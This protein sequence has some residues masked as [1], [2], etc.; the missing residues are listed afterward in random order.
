VRFAF[1]LLA[2][3]TIPDPRMIRAHGADKSAIEK[4]LPAETASHLR[5]DPDSK[6]GF[7]GFQQ[8][9][10]VWSDI[11]HINADVGRD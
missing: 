7:A 1:E 9:R 3:E 2:S 4:F 5:N 10:Q 8:L 6:I 11:S